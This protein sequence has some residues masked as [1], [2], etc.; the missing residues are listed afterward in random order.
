[1]TAL[2]GLRI[3][4]AE[5]EHVIREMLCEELESQGAIVT[6]AENGSVAF[7]H[8][9]KN[10]FDVTISDVRM[11]GGDGI[12]LMRN[13]KS[14]IQSPQYQ[15]SNR[16]TKLFLCSAFGEQAISGDNELKLNGIISK[17]FSLS[18][19]IDQI[20]TAASAS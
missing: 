13:I 19:L 5:D 8:F 14:L 1:M 6:P 7:D 17:P 9:Q 15:G 3:L 20:A 16:K 2:A 18:K 12:T 4:V 10:E 11:P